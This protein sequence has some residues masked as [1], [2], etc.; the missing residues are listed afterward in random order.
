MKKWL[1]EIRAES[2][3]KIVNDLDVTW[4]LKVGS[5]RLYHK[6]DDQMQYTLMESN[7]LPNTIK[8]I[9]VSIENSLSNLSSTEILF[10]ESITYC[11]NKL[12]QSG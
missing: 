10:K 7:H 1:L 3:R 5:F 11:K 6:P 12:R 2:N 9:L 4:N 8:Q